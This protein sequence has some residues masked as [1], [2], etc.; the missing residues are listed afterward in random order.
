ML[1]AYTL[2]ASCTPPIYTNWGVQK[3]FFDR[4][5][6]EFNICTPHYE[7]HVDAPDPDMTHDDS[8]GGLG[9]ANLD[10]RP[11]IFGNEVQIV[12][13]NAILCKMSCVRLL[14]N[15]PGGGAVECSLRQD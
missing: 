9:L 10:W 7:I 3:N 6:R 15:E 2:Q 11:L 14:E 8:P 4:S 1:T 5:A 12:C 13:L